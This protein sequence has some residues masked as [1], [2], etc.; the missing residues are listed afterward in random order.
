MQ[1]LGR[2]EA[3]SLDLMSC[4]TVAKASEVSEVITSSHFPDGITSE[5]HSTGAR[6][7]CAGLLRKEE[8]SSSRMQL[9]ENG[10]KNILL[11]ISCKSL[12][13]LFYS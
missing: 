7:L 5:I 10:R 11:I 13:G 9:L 6:L 4:A 2:E 1:D 8:A 3:V 12:L